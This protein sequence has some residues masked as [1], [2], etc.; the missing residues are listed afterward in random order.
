MGRMSPSLPLAVQSISGTSQV[1]SVNL[2]ECWRGY[3]ETSDWGP[4][5]PWASA[6]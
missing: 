4:F 6:W 1:L 2:G 5:Y 3:E